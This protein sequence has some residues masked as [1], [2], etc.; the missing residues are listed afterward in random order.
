MEK[1]KHFIGIGKKGD[2]ISILYGLQDFV[3]YSDRG[4][5]PEAYRETKS[6]RDIEEELLRG[7]RGFDTYCHGMSY[8]GKRALCANGF[9][10]NVRA[11]VIFVDNPKRAYYTVHTLLELWDGKEWKLIDPSKPEEEFK[12]PQP[13]EP[14]QY[15]RPWDFERLEIDRLSI[16]RLDRKGTTEPT[17]MVNK[18]VASDLWTAV[19][20]SYYPWKQRVVYDV[21]PF[22]ISD[23]NRSERIGTIE[24]AF[25]VYPQ[26][27]KNLSS[28]SGSTTDL[29]ELVS[30]C[31]LK[32]VQRDE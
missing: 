3:H 22:D 8:F 11:R 31:G 6:I 7:E 24:N 15:L 16:P 25:F 12:T 9:E 32:L 21:S 28:L 5:T 2:P 29:R 18:A 23:V 27:V 1:L 13:G 20:D 4:H 10:D 26:G 14:K 17:T 30:N 19:N